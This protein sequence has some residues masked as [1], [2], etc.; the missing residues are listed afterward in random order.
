MLRALA[1]VAMPVAGALA[2]LLSLCAPLAAQQADLGMAGTEWEGEAACASGSSLFTLRI[3]KVQGDR[4]AGLMIIV[5]PTAL[6]SGAVLQ[7]VAGRRTSEGGWQIMPDGRGRGDMQAVRQGMTLSPDSNGRL[8]AEFA[9]QTCTG[10]S[11]VQMTPDDLSRQATVAAPDGGRYFAAGSNEERCEAIIT[12][13]E[14]VAQEYPDLDVKRT[15]LNQVHPKVILL[16]ADEDF[17]PVFGRAFDAIP[18]R[19]RR[20]IAMDTREDCQR[21]PFVADRIRPFL[22]LYEGLLREDPNR[23]NT[24]FGYHAAVAHIRQTRVLRHQLAAA[25][26]GESADLGALLSLIEERPELLWP[27]EVQALRDKAEAAATAEAQVAAE[28]DY[29]RVAALADPLARLK[30]LSVLIAERTSYHAALEPAD[31]TA[32][33][34]RYEADEATLF[35]TL[36]EPDLATVEALP[37]DMESLA[38]LATVESSLSPPAALLSEPLREQLEDRLGAT[39]ARILDELMEADL[40]ALRALPPDRAGVEGAAA[41][42]KDFT[43][44]YAAFSEHEKYRHSLDQFARFRRDQLAAALPRFEEEL[45]AARAAGPAAVDSVL[46]AYL[47]AP[48]DDALPVSLEYLMLAEMHK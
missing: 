45:G 43:A 9:N 7:P 21:D 19:E 18:H 23:P 35:A 32:L 13:M 39:K 12:W 34:Q 31:R 4:L 36:V 28:A 26:A 20:Q 3:D 47:G 17:V 5:P 38:A 46:A 44:R 29:Q 40:A 37:S 10:L 2:A 1:L 25:A 8:T 22:G 14:R 11:L 15:V 16:F 30:A 27:S 33:R 48:G 41:W 6:R 24:S 42:Q